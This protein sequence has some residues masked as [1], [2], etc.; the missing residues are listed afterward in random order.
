MPIQTTSEEER[1]RAIAEHRKLTAP[2]VAELRAAGFGFASLDDLRRSGTQYEGAIPILISWLPKL[3]AFNVKESIVRTLSVPWARGIATKPV[4]EE[5][6]KAPKEASSLRWAIGNAM[7]V[8]ADPS[9]ADEILKI[10]ADPS[11]G[12]ARQ[13]FVLA[14]GKL[15]YHQAVPVLLALL[16]QDEVAGHAVEALGNLK[17]TEAK[18]AI[19]GMLKHPQSW[20]RKGAKTA[21]AK[22]SKVAVM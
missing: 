20:V 7:E 3:D 1:Q 18:G 11:N 21:L 16:K 5:F 4:L 9:V 17:A 22:I 14:L 2:I 12:S 13:M 8:I 10:V 19:E 6:Y 15:R